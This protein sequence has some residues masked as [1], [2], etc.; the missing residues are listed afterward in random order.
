MLEG[1]DY[2]AYCAVALAG[3]GTL[4]ETIADRAVVIR[5]NRRKR[6]E[7][8]D[9]WRE[10]VNAQE[11]KALGAALGAWMNDAVLSYPSHMP[12]EDRAAD[13]W[14]AL[15]MVADAGGGHWPHRARNAAIATSIN[16]EKASVGVQLLEDLG[17]VFGV[18][19]KLTTEQILQELSDLAEAQ[20]RHFHNDGEALNARDLS[21][22]LRPYGVRPTDVWVGGRCA[23]GYV[24]DALRDAW[25]RY[26]PVSEQREV[27]EEREELSTSH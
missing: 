3:L 21:K 15:V 1:Q 2:P 22:H 23:K 19:D 4:P 18:R 20:W 17:I 24:A 26:L 10:R 5:M 25:E 6:I 7:R 9:P 8:V 12:V 11:A 27:R 14:E 13:V 16:D